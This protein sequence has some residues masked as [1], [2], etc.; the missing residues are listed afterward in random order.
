MPLTSSMS[1]SRVSRE[2][3]GD[4]DAITLRRAQKGDRTAQAAL[5]NRYQQPVFALLWRIAGPERALVEDLAQETFLRVLRALPRFEP[6]GRARLVTW[7]LTIATRLAINHARTRVVRSDDV[8]PP[9]GVPAALLPPDQDA[10]RKKLGAALLGAIEGLGP[11]FRAA[12]LLR[13][14]HG[15]RYEEIAET[16][17]VDVGTVKS[18]LSRAR[19]LLQRAL[20]GLHDD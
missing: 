12:F 17:E 19:A 3:E 5:I 16:L 6:S 10:E 1:A 4:I 20:A 9:G 18:R 13:E 8:V 15:L 7:I 2:S 14:L 11:H